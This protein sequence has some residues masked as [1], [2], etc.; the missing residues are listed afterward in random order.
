[1]KKVVIIHGANGS[2]EENWFPWLKKELETKGIEV[3]IPQF[4]GGKD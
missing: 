2:P 4:P 1:M 3:I